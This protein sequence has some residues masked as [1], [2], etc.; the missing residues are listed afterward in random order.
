MLCTVE[1]GLHQHLSFHMHPGLWRYLQL[2]QWAL[3]L[4]K[5]KR[6]VKDSP[7]RG[8]IEGIRAQK[9]YPDPNSPLVR[10]YISLIKVVDE[11]IKG[12]PLNPP[13]SFE[14]GLWRVSSLPVVVFDIINP[15]TLHW[16][17]IK[18]GVWRKLLM[19]MSFDEHVL[20]YRLK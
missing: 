3:S 16:R 4:I 12:L 2:Q 20:V 7:W 8:K 19:M 14:C 9:F 11:F 10:L 1:W 5:Q 18:K 15:S 17:K 6:R 13:T